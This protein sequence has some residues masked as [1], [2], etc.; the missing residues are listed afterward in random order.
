MSVTLEH[1]LTDGELKKPP[2]EHWKVWPG[3]AIVATLPCGHLNELE[4]HAICEDGTLIPSVV[5]AA[6]GNWGVPADWHGA[7]RLQDWDPDFR[8]G[9]PYTRQERDH[10]RYNRGSGNRSRLCP[11]CCQPWTPGHNPDTCV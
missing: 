4:G 6:H 1:D 10:D 3:G 8:A 5:C 2:V 7:I 9:W 11:V